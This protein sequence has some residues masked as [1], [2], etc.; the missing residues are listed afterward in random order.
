MTVVL[1]SLIS[2]IFFFLISH[3]VYCVLSLSSQ[4]NPPS[5]AFF[6]IWYVLYNIPENTFVRLFREPAVFLIS[7]IVSL[8]SAARRVNL[9]SN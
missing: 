9:G 5:Y 8:V 4:G 3:Y 7:R 2:I 6:V 1:P